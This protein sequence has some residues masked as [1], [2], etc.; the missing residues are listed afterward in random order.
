MPSSFLFRFLARRK[1]LKIAKEEL[2]NAQLNLS[3]SI[4]A[5]P[6]E[7]K[8]AELAKQISDIHDG[9]EAIQMAGGKLLSRRAVWISSLSTL[10]AALALL[11]NTSAWY[12][13]QDAKH[14]EAA[15]TWCAKLYDPNY[16]AYQSVARRERNSRFLLPDG[17][18][19]QAL[20]VSSNGSIDETKIASLEK[21]IA[22]LFPEPDPSKPDLYASLIGL[23]NLIDVGSLMVLQGDMEGPRFVSCF[24][25]FAETYYKKFDSSYVGL[26]YATLSRENH[27]QLQTALEV[28]PSL[29]CVFYQ[30]SCNEARTKIWNGKIVC[31]PGPLKNRN[32]RIAGANPEGASTRFCQ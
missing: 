28:F 13:Q 9:L 20:N 11:F 30:K 8:R 4:A 6:D 18:T 29:A 21:D 19:L 26:K 23:L 27:K 17:L 10:L 2:T 31:Q 25:D 5:E 16:V 32:V 24:R 3:K 15:L 12:S 1:R 7:A 14:A 22:S